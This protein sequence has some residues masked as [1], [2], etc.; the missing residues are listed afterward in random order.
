VVDFELRNEKPDKISLS[1]HL[2]KREK[3]K[4]VESIHLPEN[5]L[6]FKRLEVL[7]RE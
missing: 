5:K 6:A 4:V 3:K 7:L 2:T 1:W